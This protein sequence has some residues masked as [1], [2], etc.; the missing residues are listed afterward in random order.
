MGEFG[1]QFSPKVGFCPSLESASGSDS[2]DEATDQRSAF[3]FE[4]LEGRRLKLE[5]T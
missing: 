5:A 3:G 4:R 2:V 1:G